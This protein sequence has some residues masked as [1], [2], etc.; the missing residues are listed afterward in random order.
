[1]R[2]PFPAHSR[3]RRATR[4]LIVSD[5]HGQLHPGVAA[6][7]RDCDMAV[8]AGDI[9]DIAVIRALRPRLRR[10]I[11]V[12]GNNDTRAKWSAQQYAVLDTIPLCARLQLAGGTLVVEHG[13]R[14]GKVA[15]RHQALRERHPDARLIVY[16][17]SHRLCC[18]LDAEPWVVN[19]GAAGRART[20]G[21]ASCLVLHIR[22]A[23]WD[24]ATHRFAP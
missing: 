11:A 17:H 4:I 13:H 6:L 24:I 20:F 22:D 7:A 18:D 5:T 3:S 2:S 12:L 10:T 23:R 1:L 9:G 16:G 8:H 21:G 14:T 19:P 15:T